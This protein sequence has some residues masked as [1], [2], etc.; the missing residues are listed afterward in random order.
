MNYLPEYIFYNRP[1]DIS[2]IIMTILER[3]RDRIYWFNDI[4]NISKRVPT[5]FMIKKLKVYTG[6]KIYFKLSS[7]MTHNTSLF[8]YEFY[9]GINIQ[10]CYRKKSWNSY[11]L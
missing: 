6:I 3:F 11:A 2:S 1:L 5:F 8:K 10:L 4:Y 9:S 7:V